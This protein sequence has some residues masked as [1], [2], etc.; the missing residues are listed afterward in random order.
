MSLFLAESNIRD[1]DTITARQDETTN[2]YIITY[3][4]Q[5]LAFVDQEDALGQYMEFLEHAMQF[6]K[7]MV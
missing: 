7:V 4:E 3:G 6:G 5:R 2:E 1:A